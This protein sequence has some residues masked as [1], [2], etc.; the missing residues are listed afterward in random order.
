MNRS[1]EIPIFFSIDNHYAPFLA[2]ALNSAIANSSC[3][4]SYRA[5]VLY[6]DLLPEH[7]N[8]IRQLEKEHF[9]IDFVPV[10]QE[11]QS[12]TDRMSNRLRCDYF[13][14]TIYFRLF[15]PTLF[16]QYEKG[17]Y[18]DSDVIVQGDLAELY[19]TE[20]GDNY[21]AACTDLSVQQVPPLCQYM[22]QAVGVPRKQ[23][24][25]SGVLLMNLQ[26]LRE[27]S[28]DQHFLRLLETYHFDCI[29]PDQD[30]LNA[31]C[32]GRIHYLDPVW[33]TMPSE[34]AAPVPDARLIHYN[35]FSKPWC[36]DGIAY[37]DAF[38][39]YAETSGYYEEC[40]QY[41]DN[42]TDEKKAADSKCMQLL[43]ERGLEITQAEI[44][45]KNMHEKGE[46]VRL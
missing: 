32:C 20:L 5:V 38:W 6:Q 9:K 23:Y 1:H 29:A 15:I 12:I 45:F 41:K 16:P 11:F 40:L 37:A 31:L 27:K 24:I 19:D 3:N 39:R 42:Y 30:Y 44:T 21:L 43:V 2:A 26:L 22:E 46:C 35:L 4:R 18:I 13:T 14:L 34:T 7:R 36:Y 10:E 8:R 33:N 17:I 28:L 25:N